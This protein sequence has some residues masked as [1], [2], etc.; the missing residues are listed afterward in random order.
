MEL[1]DISTAGQ[2]V[3]DREDEG[4]LVHLRDE[5]NEKQYQDEAQTK[6]V[7]MQVV[8]TYSS[9]YRRLLDA[10][11]DRGLKRRSS[12][13]D[14]DEL[15]QRTLELIA[16]CTLGWDGLTVNGQPLPF[17]KPNA[18]A[19]LRAMPWIREQIE[20]AMNDHQLYFRAN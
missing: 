2:T 9:R 12:T 7:T 6:P 17:S 15:E 5:M 10:Q 20:A 19:I 13:V 18:I 8:G 1:K 3:A 4:T 16:G 11:R 14:G